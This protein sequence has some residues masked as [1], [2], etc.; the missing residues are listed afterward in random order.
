LASTVGEV[1]PRYMRLTYF[2]FLLVLAACTDSIPPEAN[3]DG[4]PSRQDVSVV[5]TSD[6]F[7]PPP[8]PQRCDN[9]QSE[10]AEP[11]PAIIL[12]IGD[13]MGSEHIRAASLARHGVANGL[14]L[15]NA[16]EHHGKINTFSLSGTTDSGAAAT[17]MGCGIKSINYRVG[18]DPLGRPCPNIFEM[19]HRQGF[20]TG[21]VTTAEVVDAT[22]AGFALHQQNRYAFTDLVRQLTVL[23]PAVILGGG[24]EA[25]RETDIESL[26]A[27]GHE[28][29]R[30][31]EEL[32]GL[33]E[34]CGVLGLFADGPMEDAHSRADD[35][36]QP[37]LVQMA[38]QA[39][40]VLEHSPG[41]FLLLIENEGIDNGSHRNDTEGVLREV[42][43]LD[44][45]VAEVIAW[46]GERQDVTIAV[47]ADH[48][49]GDLQVIDDA[50]TVSW[51]QTSHSNAPIDIFASGPGT[52]IFA[53]EVRDNRW[54][55]A[56]VESLILAQD[57]QAPSD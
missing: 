19:A 42:S 53:N 45:T 34:P 26:R 25:F 38:R 32:N 30:T 56:L 50:P 57:I 20:R 29:V 47:L 46:A 35:S 7:V 14:V 37:R 48:E 12:L 9:E 33:G 51:G 15:Q 5:H 10:A 21:I 16:F 13:G 54:I 43:E 24:R 41:G 3:Q 44:D 17:A 18:L 40:A 2:Y 39:L 36:T 28:Y 6:I 11:G 4:S 1:Y 22:P 27:A 49:C 31:A 23:R 52:K 55:H 8:D